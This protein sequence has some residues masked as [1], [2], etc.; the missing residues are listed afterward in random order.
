[1]LLGV[2]VGL[3]VVQDAAREAFFF[4]LFAETFVDGRT[5]A[6]RA[7]NEAHIFSANAVAQ[8]TREAV[9]GNE[10]AAHM[11]KVKTLVTVRHA[12]SHHCALGPFLL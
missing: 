1:M 2:V 5:V 11:S 8:E 12:R 10:D 4:D 7:R 6:V 3:H 9:G